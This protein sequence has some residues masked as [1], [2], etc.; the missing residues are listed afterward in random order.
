MDFKKT[1]PKKLC[2]DCCKGNQT[3]QPSRTPMSQ[4]TE[5][6]SQVYSDLE[7]SFS[8]TRHGYRYYI[9]FLKESTSLIDIKPLK[10]KDDILAV[11]KNYK[12]LREK[13]SDCQLKVLHIDRGGKY[14]R[15]FDNYLK[16][17]S[18][19]Y[20]ITALYSFEQNRQAV[21]VNRT[22]M[23][24]VRAIFAQQKLPNLLWVEIAKVVVYL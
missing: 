19:T 13:Q 14:V 22:I 24:S 20:K 10:Y 4:S 12:T 8:R 3:R 15:E 6:L 7:R 1:T 5:F 16:E 21:R 2:G 23:D 9:S 17:N 11:F 18:I